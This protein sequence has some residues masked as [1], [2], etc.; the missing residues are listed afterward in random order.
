[1][2]GLLADNSEDGSRRRRRGCH[3]DNSVTFERILG[4]SA[5]RSRRARY[6]VGMLPVGFCEAADAKSRRGWTRVGEDVAYF[7][8]SRT[9]PRPSGNGTRWPCSALPFE[10]RP[11]A[12]QRCKHQSQRW[13][14]DRVAARAGIRDGR[15]SARRASR[16]RSPARRSRNPWR[17][18]GRT[19]GTTTRCRSSSPSRTARISRATRRTTRRTRRRRGGRRVRPTTINDLRPGGP[20]ASRRLLGGEEE[21]ETTAYSSRTASLIPTQTCDESSARSTTARGPPWSE[22]GGSARR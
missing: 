14:Y 17:Q 20:A 21:G 13:S 18:Q 2:T 6:D 15:G 5:R 10:R 16:A 9:Y 8:N 19:T 12:V 7:K 11:P 3:V 22:D 4:F 1:M